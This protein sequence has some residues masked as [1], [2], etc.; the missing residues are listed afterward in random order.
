MKC[1][2]CPN[3]KIREQLKYPGLYGSQPVCYSC[4]SYTAKERESDDKFRLDYTLKYTLKP[5]I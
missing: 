2:H 1:M 3:R 4:E 5:L